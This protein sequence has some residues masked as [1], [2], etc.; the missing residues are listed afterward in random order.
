MSGASFQLP[1]IK[2]LNH[3]IVNI[4]VDIQSAFDTNGIGDFFPPVQLIAL[5]FRCRFCPAVD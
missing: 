4:F 5:R 1:R 3:D 2:F